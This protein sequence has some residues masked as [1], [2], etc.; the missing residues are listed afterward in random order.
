VYYAIT[1]FWFNKKLVIY[2]MHWFLDGKIWKDHIDRNGL[3]NQRSN[4]RDC[5]NSKNQ[6]NKIKSKNKSSIYKG[7]CYLKKLNKWE[8]RIQI[9]GIST[10]IGRYKD[11][12]FAAK[13]YDELAKIYHKEFARLNFP[14]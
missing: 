2:K 3:N 7:V 4:I 5:D 14:D 9:N 8:V 10:L 13:K 11:E 1:N 12:I 6:M